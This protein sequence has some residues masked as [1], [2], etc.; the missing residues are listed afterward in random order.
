MPFNMT[1]FI[2]AANGKPSCIPLRSSSD[3]FEVDAGITK[4]DLTVEYAKTELG[5]RIG[6]VW[7]GFA[8]VLT[9]TSQ[10]I[11][12][13]IM[14]EPRQRAE[15]NNIPKGINSAVRNSRAV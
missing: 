1:D 10:L 4:D 2:G 14:T 15:A 3:R 7:I 12:F 6:Y 8:Q 11:K 9:R 5:P 13:D